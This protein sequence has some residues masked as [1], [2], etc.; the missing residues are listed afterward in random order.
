MSHRRTGAIL[1]HEVRLL[2]RDPLPI[3]ILVVFPLLLIAFLK[4]MFALALTTH[5]HP[6]AN[7]AEQVY[8]VKP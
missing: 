5:G 7:G 8:L 6:G 4:P 1:L 2:S 3:M